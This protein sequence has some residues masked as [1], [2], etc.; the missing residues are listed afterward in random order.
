M[1]DITPGEGTEVTNDPVNST[2]TGYK[3]RGEDI[4]KYLQRP[5]GNM[6]EK[7]L[8]GSYKKNG[9]Q[10]LFVDSNSIYTNGL[11]P[12]PDQDPITELT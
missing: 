4:V 5:D 7:E 3:I 6:P 8:T 9:A 12:P 10:M 11:T 2:L 1:P